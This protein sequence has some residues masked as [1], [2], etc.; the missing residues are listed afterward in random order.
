MFHI[1][2]SLFIYC[3]T[4]IQALS[5][6]SILQYT[7]SGTDGRG[8]CFLSP[9]HFMYQD[10]SKIFCIPMLHA[11]HG[12]LVVKLLHS[13]WCRKYFR[14][15]RFLSVIVRP[16]VTRSYRFYPISS[17][18]VSVLI[19]RKHWKQEHWRYIVGDFLG[20]SNFR[21]FFRIFKFNSIFKRISHD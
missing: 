21:G 11:A 3:K 9:F 8:G 5:D 10:Y 7:M 4:E 2:F 19:I 13:D 15:Q 18:Y 1:V 20:F 14:D 6:F 17:R 12:R 16:T